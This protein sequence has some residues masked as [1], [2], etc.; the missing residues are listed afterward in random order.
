MTL[1]SASDLSIIKNAILDIV[2]DTSI[3]T[4]IKYRQATGTTTAYSVET[5][6]MAD[7]MFTDWSGVSAIMGVFTQRE[8][9]GGVEAGDSKFVI[10]QSSVS[11]EL[12]TADIIVESGTS[13]NI[14]QIRRDPL[15]IVYIIAATSAM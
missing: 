11:G 1:L 15:E 5:Q 14:K 7:S 10:M 8:E 9:G 4:T 2:Q 6:S 12:T 13:Y 3:N